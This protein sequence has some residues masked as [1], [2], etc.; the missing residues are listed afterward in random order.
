MSDQLTEDQ[1]DFFGRVLADEFFSD[2]ATLIEKKGVTED[3]IRQ[4]LSVLN[5]KLGKIGACVVVLMPTLVNET[6]DAPG[7]QFQVRLTVQVVDQP[8][9]N[10]DPAQGT[11]KSAAQLAERLRKIFHHFSTGRGNFFVFAAQEP[12][13]VEEG[14]NS[15]G[16]AFTRKGA[17]CPPPKP[18]TPTIE[19]AA[20]TAPT[21]VTLTC[22]NPSAAIHYT[23]DGSYPSAANPTATLYTV[24][25]NQATAATIKAASSLATYQQSNLARKVIA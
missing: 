20:A 10:L 23:T 11:G 15:Y 12:I 5:E 3:D 9:V 2:I 16:V 4:S 25:F 7:P 24:P 1:E 18:P 6:P 13:P 22:A 17:D 8:L 14:K 19:A 21:T